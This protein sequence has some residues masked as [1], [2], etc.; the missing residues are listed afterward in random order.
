MAAVSHL[1]ALQGIAE[2]SSLTLHPGKKDWRG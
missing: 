2:R 1:K